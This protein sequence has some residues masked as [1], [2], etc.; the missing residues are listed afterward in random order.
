MKQRVLLLGFLWSTFFLQAQHNEKV[1]EYRY[2]R[3][4]IYSEESGLLK[5]WPEN[6]PRLVWSIDSGLGMGYPSPIITDKYIYLSGMIDSTGHMYCIDFDGNIV[7]DVIY[8]KEWNKSFPG[9]RSTV[10]IKGDALY[11]LTGQ[12]V[13]MRMNAYTGEIVWQVDLQEKYEAEPPFFGFTESPLLVDDNV[14]F[15]P[16]G[17]KGYIVL[18]KQSDGSQVWATPSKGERSG[19]CSAVIFEHNGRRIV[20]NMTHKHL[21]GVDYVT[22]DT[23]W[24]FYSYK[25]WTDN[26][27]SPIYKNGELFMSSPYGGG[28][29]MFT[30]NDDG[31]AISQK[32][33]NN[34]FDNQIGGVAVIDGNIYGVGVNKK[35]W[36]CVDWATGETKWAARGLGVGS[37]IAADGMLYYYADNGDLALVKPNAE[38]FEIVSRFKVFDGKQQFSHPVIVNGRLYIRYHHGM[39]VFD[40]RN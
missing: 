24:T 30:L 40:I 6:G 37:L 4:G 16:G 28:A 33:F 29:Y 23:L 39:K 14:V 31:T 8:G 1:Y 9:A 13:A 5:Q 27:L 26:S 10:T 19:Y 15:T 20:A 2:D 7:W 25:N 17:K 21:M 3:T 38:S 32:W 18:L 12:G 11:T 35:H 22:G 34:A 36:M